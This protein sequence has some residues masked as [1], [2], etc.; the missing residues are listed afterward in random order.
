MEKFNQN[1]NLLEEDFSQIDEENNS[2]TEKILKVRQEKYNSELKRTL[3]E[4]TLEKA[5]QIKEL[6]EINRRNEIRK[7][8]Q[9]KELEEQRKKLEILT[10]IQEFKE[11]IDLEKQED[12][13]KKGP[14]KK[15]NGFSFE[16]TVKA[17]LENIEGDTITSDINL[18][19]LRKKENL[20][21]IEKLN[22]VDQIK[23]LL[24]TVLPDKSAIAESYLKEEDKTDDPQ[25]W[26][27]KV[28]GVD[29]QPY[30]ILKG[31]TKEGKD[32]YYPEIALVDLTT[33]SNSIKI[34]R[35]IKNHIK[36]MAVYY[37]LTGKNSFP[38]ILIM[39]DRKFLKDDGELNFKNNRYKLSNF[40]SGYLTKILDMPQNQRPAYIKFSEIQEVYNN[41]LDTYDDPERPKNSWK[42]REKNVQNHLIRLSNIELEI[43]KKNRYNS[44]EEYLEKEFDGDT[45]KRI[46]FRKSA[47]ENI[48]KGYSNQQIFELL[49]KNQKE[50][51]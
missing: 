25:A 16:D 14:Q 18:P 51:V 50:D 3:E 9:A 44:D 35:K 45:E 20:K 2:Y 42:K 30:Q 11:K 13:E 46:L 41:D 8:E 36:S 21:L 27:D 12:L 17:A 31:E 22:D 4:R 48:S 39:D 43:K 6:E 40:I 28:A 19:S 23:D 37:E 33:D 34:K 38:I 5:L 10:K 49:P 26:L 24:Y 7:L 29:M 47:L 1:Q 32:I 15:Y